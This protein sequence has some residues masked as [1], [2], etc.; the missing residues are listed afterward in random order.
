MDPTPLAT[1]ERGSGVPIVLVPGLTFTRHVWDPIADRLAERHRV[2]MVDLPGHGDSDGSAADQ[3]A[4]AERLHAT[5][6]A[7]G[8][9]AP[10]M[11]G[12]SAGAMLATGYASRWPV[13]AVVNVDQPLTVAAFAAFVQ[14]KADELRGP[15]F[16]EAF[17]PFEDS[18]GCARLPEPERTRVQALRQIRQDVV[19]D[20]WHFPLTTEPGAMQRIVDAMLEDVSA[21]YVYVAGD[22]PPAPVREHLL[23]HAQQ[24]R[25]VVWPGGGHLVHLLDPE[26]F[27]GLVAG[28]V[29]GLA[30]G[31]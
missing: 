23:A 16:T 31:D 18:I 11:V 17:A 14:Q 2:V 20:A 19:L 29:A 13:R 4:V 9:E 25:I 26:R 7:L 30:D 3:R 15:S 27:A 12:H 8:V 5:L 6:A 1:S 10:V 24:P 22:E 21:P 28:L